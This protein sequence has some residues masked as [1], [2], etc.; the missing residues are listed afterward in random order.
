MIGCLWILH[1]GQASLSKE[2]SQILA[3]SYRFAE[4]KVNSIRHHHRLCS[5]GFGKLEEISDRDCLEVL[6]LP[7]AM[8]HCVCSPGSVNS[9]SGL[10][11]EI[12]DTEEEGSS[13]PKVY[14][15]PPLT[16]SKECLWAGE[17]LT[18]P[19]NDG[20]GV[21]FVAEVNF[22]STRW[23]TSTVWWMGALAQHN[24]FAVRVGL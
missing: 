10:Q 16:I 8:T 2:L 20:I 22:K 18:Q 9:L 21:L 14:Y 13:T 5:H 6:V 7:R 4:V 23:D 24:R 1:V 12:E 19:G 17:A 11:C 15:S 3:S